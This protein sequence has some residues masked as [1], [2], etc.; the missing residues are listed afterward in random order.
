M[1]ERILAFFGAAIVAAIVGLLSTYKEYR[2][3]A[4]V[5]I[6]LVGTIGG[7]LAIFQYLRGR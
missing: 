5:A 2:Q 4:D 7:I 1:N 6:M 3:I